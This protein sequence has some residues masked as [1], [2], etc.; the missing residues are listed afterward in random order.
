[1]TNRYKRTLDELHDVAAMFWP[2]E[3][4]QQEAE[5]SIIPKL[6]ETQDQFI[7]ILSVETPS[8]DEMF[9][10][11]SAATMSPNLFLKHL[12]V[13]SDVGGE[14]LQ[15]YNRE[16]RQLF[17]D[18]A[19]RYIRDQ[20]IFAYNFHQLPITGILNND[21]LGISGKKLLARRSF[22]TLLKDVAVILMFGSACQN[23]STAEILN[24]CEIGNYVGSPE[25]LATFVKQRYIIVSRITSGAKTNTL[26]QVAQHFVRDYLVEKLPEYDFSKKRISGI[27]HNQNDDGTSF[28]VVVSNGEKIVGIEVSFQVTTNSV[29]ERKAGQARSR[30]EQIESHGYK[31]AYVLDGAGNFQRRNA[32]SNICDYSH[33]T[34]AFTRPELDIL[35]QFI[36]DYF[37]DRL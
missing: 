25:K 5:V 32:V 13:L 27:L 9:S 35:V 23:E 20:K 24:K 6:L 17:P 1:M 2:P 37:L 14:Q 18:G 8:H 36:K 3:L 31:I 29:I 12:S 33:C 26:G 11:I 4:S 22:D 28:D 30:Y 10:V 15:R 7:A 16:F 19:I 34:V 21:K